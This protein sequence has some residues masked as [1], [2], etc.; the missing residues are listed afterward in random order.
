MKQRSNA[1]HM[2]DPPTLGLN[3]DRCITKTAQKGFLAQKYKDEHKDE[4][5][6]E[7]NQD[8]ISGNKAAQIACQYI[9]WLLSTVN[10]NLP[11]DGVWVRPNCH[12]SQRHYQDIPQCE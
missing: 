4:N 12:P 5:R 11:D 10:P 8:I 6:P 7:L 2:P 9:D 3:I 1:P